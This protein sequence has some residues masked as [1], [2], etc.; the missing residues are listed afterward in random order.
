ARRHRLVQR[1]LYV[2]RVAYADAETVH[3]FRYRGEIGLSVGIDFILVALAPLIGCID[4]PPT[5]VEPT[6]VVDDSY[7]VKP[8]PTG[9]LQFEQVIHKAAI[10]RETYDWAVGH[11]TF[12]AN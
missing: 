9:G 5:L 10:A 2:R 11:C 12:D 8:M 6:V 3:V 4:G 1:F 7:G